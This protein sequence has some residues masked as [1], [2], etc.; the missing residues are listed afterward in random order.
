MIKPILKMGH[1]EL[2][3][4]SALVQKDEFKTPELQAI[5]NELW[6]NRAHY[7]GAGLSAPQ[8]GIFKQIVVVGFEHNER[9][10]NKGSV[11]MCCMINPTIDV[12]TDEQ[13]EDWEGC[14]SVPGIR[15]LVPRFTE[16][17]YQYFDV[18][19]EH[20]EQLASGFHARVIQHEVDHLSGILFPER[21]KNFKKLGYEDSLPEF[22][23]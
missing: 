12:L 17:K 11:P 7:D 23:Q 18:N 8:L 22:A 2:M 9:Y 3:K 1:P 6:E 14:L 15:G 10:K 21:V 16:I 5:V 19:G 20:Y 13:E 4:P